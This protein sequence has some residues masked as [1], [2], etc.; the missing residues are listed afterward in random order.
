MDLRARDLL[1]SVFGETSICRILLAQ[2]R[3]PRLPREARR[4]GHIFVDLE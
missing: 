2:F 4:R 1:D 3:R